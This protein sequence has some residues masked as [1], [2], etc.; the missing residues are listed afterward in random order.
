MVHALYIWY[1]VTL[2]ISL[3]ALPQL[4]EEINTYF[5][6]EIIFSLNQKVGHLYVP[7]CILISGIAIKFTV[8]NIGFPTGNGRAFGILSN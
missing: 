6:L 5:I 1:I 7:N 4:C 8:S 2:M 3:R